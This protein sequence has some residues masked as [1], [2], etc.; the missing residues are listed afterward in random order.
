MPFGACCPASVMLVN[1]RG[2]D[3]VCEACVCVCVCMETKARGL[4]HSVWNVPKL[5]VF[6]SQRANAVM[7]SA[8]IITENKNSFSQRI[9]DKE[10][11]R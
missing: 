11:E 1:E 7:S 8:E 3:C 9:G 6:S 5:S 4:A 10:I 2:E